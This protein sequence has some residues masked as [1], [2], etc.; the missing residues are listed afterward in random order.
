MAIS[1][2]LGIEISSVDSL[3]LINSVVEDSRALRAG[4]HPSG[5]ITAINYRSVCGMTPDQ[6]V[7]QMRGAPGSEVT[8]TIYRRNLHRTFPVTMTH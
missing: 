6:A 1:H 3:M 2:W 8:L 7:A 4:I 5:V